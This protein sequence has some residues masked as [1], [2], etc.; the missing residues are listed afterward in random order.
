MATKP[1]KDKFNLDHGS[2][3]G[4]L[5]QLSDRVRSSGWT[6]IN[7][8]PPDL[9]DVDVVIDL[10]TSYGNITLEKVRAH[11]E[12]YVDGQNCAAQDSMQMYQCIFNSLSKSA[13]AIVAL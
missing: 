9:N 8:I 2:L 4:F 11:A 7:Q 6:D 12:T 13:Q 3:Y 5:K 1:L 10:I